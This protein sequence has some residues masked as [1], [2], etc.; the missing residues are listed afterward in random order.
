MDREC[1]EVTWLA[2]GVQRA[3]AG[4]QASGAGACYGF[5]SVALAAQSMAEVSD[6]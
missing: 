1:V 3:A 6:M 5:A 2:G 4:K